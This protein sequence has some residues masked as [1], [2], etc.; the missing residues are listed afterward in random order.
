MLFEN[1]KLKRLV[2]SFT[3]TKRF[4]A[5]IKETVDYVLS[6]KECQ[7][8]DEKFDKWCDAVVEATRDAAEV[9]KRYAYPQ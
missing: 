2:P 6:H 5:G 9:I 7:M 1:T 3:A 4:D 8:P